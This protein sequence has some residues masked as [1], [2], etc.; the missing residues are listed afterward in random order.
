MT[1]GRAAAIR[2]RGEGNRNRR[3]LHCAALRSG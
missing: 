1:K 3:S 2:S